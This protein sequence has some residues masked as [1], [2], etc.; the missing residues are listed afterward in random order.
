MAQENNTNNSEQLVFEKVNYLLT[1]IGAV[2]VVVGFF[3][4]SG[5]GSDDPSVFNEEIFSF[6]RVTLA[7]LVI[8]AGYGV[9]FFAIMKKPK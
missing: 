5:G 8:L 7:P 2:M 1:A 4:M 6:T 3:L 9:V